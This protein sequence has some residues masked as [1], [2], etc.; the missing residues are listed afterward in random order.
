MALKTVEMP[1]L[2]VM[3]TGVFEACAALWLMVIEQDSMTQY[4][5]WLQAQCPA[6][7]LMTPD[8]C[9]ESKLSG[10]Q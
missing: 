2:E 3:Q 7:V 1:A 5:G 10:D 9:I 8:E 4:G 6:L